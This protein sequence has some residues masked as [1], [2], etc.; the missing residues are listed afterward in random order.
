MDCKRVEYNVNELIDNHDTHFKCSA[1]R[2]KKVSGVDFK[3]FDSLL[4]I[5]V[6]KINNQIY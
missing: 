1:D 3:Q 2:A 5:S 6:Q 4:E